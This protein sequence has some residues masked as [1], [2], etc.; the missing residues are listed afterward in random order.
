[1]AG[2]VVTISI[3][4]LPMAQ[5][6]DRL[7]RLQGPPTVRIYEVSPRDG[8]QNEPETVSTEDKIELLRRLAAS[9]LR[10]IEVTSF[11]RPSWIPQLSDA[12]ELV[13]ALPTLRR[14]A[15]EVRFWALV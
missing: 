1:M 15:P 7:T 13:Q 4:G 8:L 6:D 11:V 12:A 2:G 5:P 3:G 9:G 14:E 10:D